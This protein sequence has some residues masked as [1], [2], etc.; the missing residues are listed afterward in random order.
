MLPSSDASMK[1]LVLTLL[2][3]TS[4][5]TSGCFNPFE[6]PLALLALCGGADPAETRS[7]DEF[8]PL[9]LGGV[10]PDWDI[11]SV[12]EDLEYEQLRFTTANPSLLDLEIPAGE[13]SYESAGAAQLIPIDVGITTNTIETISNGESDVVLTY[14]TITPPQKL[15]QI[16]IAESQGPMARE[17]KLDDAGQVKRGSISPTGEALAHVIRNRVELIR[18]TET[19]G[20]FAADDFDFYADPP[21]SEYDAVIEAHL[22]G[23][24]Q[25]SPVDPSDINHDIYLNADER[26]NLDESLLQ[27]AYDQAVVSAAFVFS[28]TL[29]DSTRDAFGFY[30]PTDEEYDVLEAALLSKTRDLPEN[31]GTGDDQFPAFAPIQILILSNIVTRTEESTVP[32]FVFVRTRTAEEPAVIAN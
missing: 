27:R 1:F 9:A 23:I 11:V 14:E 10:A 17:A 30:S 28:G 15:I 13:T 3:V 2:F 29:T 21:T 25:F 5:T 32:A 24:Y 7:V 4:L 6:C 16:L 8:Y 12:E 18:E 26:A 22:G 31:I 19:P 20:L